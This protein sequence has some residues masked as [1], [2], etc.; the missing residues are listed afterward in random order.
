MLLGNVPSD[1]KE[2]KE[3]FMEF[4]KDPEISRAIHHFSDVDKSNKAQ[5]HTLG[6][7]PVEALPGNTKVG[8]KGF[9]PIADQSN[10]TLDKT[11]YTNPI[12]NDDTDFITTLVFNNHDPDDDTIN[13]P[14]TAIA[15]ALKG[16]DF[17]RIVI[18]S[19]SEK[20]IYFGDGTTDPVNEIGVGFYCKD[21]G[22]GRTAA[23]LWAHD[24]EFNVGSH[25]VH[26]N[27]YSHSHQPL[28]LQSSA[29]I[30]SGIGDPD[31]N[32]NEGDFYIKEDGDI[33]S[34]DVLWRCTSAP[35]TWE[36][37]LAPPPGA[38]PPTVAVTAQ[39]L[40]FY[41]AGSRA[42]GKVTVDDIYGCTICINTL[43]QNLPP[44]SSGGGLGAF[45]G[46]PSFDDSIY[47]LNYS[48]RFVVQN[49]NNTEQGIMYVLGGTLSSTEG[50]TVI[51]D[52]YSIDTGSDLVVDDTGS[53]TLLMSTAGGVYYGQ[54]VVN[55]GMVTI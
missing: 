33:S 30:H 9:V 51:F 14:T 21:I 49:Q 2:F 31:E 22:S 10:Y 23:T 17:P 45:V 55:F 34:F 26:L 40:D 29:A 42:T 11:T 52:G 47:Q 12:T 20:G 15:I 44:A 18:S 54:L 8:G 6:T 36:Q 38:G 37:I 32:G 13:I 27:R 35:D 50:I 3:W 39:I 4:A 5:H 43:P 1:P 48:V 19:D 46:A 25:D 16:D 7:R 41:G 24:A 28:K 53:P